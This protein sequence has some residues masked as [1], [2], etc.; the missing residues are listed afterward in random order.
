MTIGDKAKQAVII[1]DDPG[2]PEPKEGSITSNSQNVADVITR[3][4]SMIRK[5]STE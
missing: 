5:W 3:K 4:P 1:G 2:E